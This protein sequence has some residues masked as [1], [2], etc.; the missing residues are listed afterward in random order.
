[1]TQRCRSA[2]PVPAGAP[3]LVAR[4]TARILVD[5]QRETPVQSMRDRSIFNARVPP[6]YATGP[7]RMARSF[8]VRA[9]CRHL[10]GQIGMVSIR[11]GRD[12]STAVSMLWSYDE[13]SAEPTQH[14]M[15]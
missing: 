9:P 5:L 11:A 14:A 15:D 3:K 6:R 8:F 10:P 12:D 4:P 13:P 7:L 2:L 1:M